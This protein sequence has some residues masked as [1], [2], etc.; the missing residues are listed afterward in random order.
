QVIAEERMKTLS[1]EAGSCQRQTTHLRLHTVTYAAAFQV[2]HLVV[3]VIGGLVS[4]VNPSVDGRTT[5]VELV[6]DL[7]LETRGILIGLAR[8]A[9]AVVGVDR[10]HDTDRN[11]QTFGQVVVAISDLRGREGIRITGANV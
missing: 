6:A 5:Q 10:I 7:G 9:A 4:G 3:S 1:L 8:R 11:A 2:I